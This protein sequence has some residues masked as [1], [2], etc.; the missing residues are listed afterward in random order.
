[1]PV[2]AAR[3]R[4]GGDAGRAP[5]GRRQPRIRC[6]HRFGQRT[7]PAEALIAPLWSPTPLIVHQVVAHAVDATDTTNAAI[8]PSDVATIARCQLGS[9]VVPSDPAQTIHDSRLDADVAAALKPDPTAARYLHQTTVVRQT[10]TARSAVY[11][12]VCQMIGCV[13]SVDVNVSDVNPEAPTPK[14]QV[15]PDPLYNWSKPEAGVTA[16]TANLASVPCS[17][18]GFV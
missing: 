1:V 2:S 16:G 15:P 8:I 3:G 5:P 13:E 18:D 9:G 17:V 11:G 10:P 4:S 6:C 12:F 7:G 14:V